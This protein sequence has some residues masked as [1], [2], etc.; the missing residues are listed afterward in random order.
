MA[1]R[2]IVT[3]SASRPTNSQ[4]LA[5]KLS[6]TVASPK[7]ILARVVLPMPPAP[8]TAMVGMRL[9]P[10]PASSRS[11]VLLTRMS[12]SILVSSAIFSPTTSDRMRPSAVRRPSPESARR[13]QQGEGDEEMILVWETKPKRELLLS[14]PSSLRLSALTLFPISR[15]RTGSRKQER[16][17]TR[18]PRKQ[19]QQ[20]AMATG[21]AASPPA[22]AWH[23]SRMSSASYMASLSSRTHRSTAASR[24]RAL[25]A[26]ERTARRSPSVASSLEISPGTPSS[27]STSSFAVSARMRARLDAKA[28]SIAAM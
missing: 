10:P 4:I 9:Q 16:A 1:L 5:S 23:S 15:A 6:W 7:T 19:Q 13:E 28:S 24:S 8:V 21:V 17:G 12:A 14:M 20:P 18:T 25:S 26:S 22:A 3:S 2:S 27:A 11:V